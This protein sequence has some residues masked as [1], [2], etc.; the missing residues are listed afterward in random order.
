MTSHRGA[1]TDATTPPPPRH[2]GDV[3]APHS[4]QEPTTSA[5][6]TTARSGQPPQAG[7]VE[8][9]RA[10][11]ATEDRPAMTAEPCAASSMASGPVLAQEPRL[12]GKRQQM[13]CLL[14]WAALYRGY[15]APAP[16]LGT[17]SDGFDHH[18]G[19]GDLT[20]EHDL[21]AALG[22]L[23]ARRHET[24]AQQAIEGVLERYRREHGLVIDLDAR[25]IT[26]DSAFDAA[27]EEGWRRHAL[28]WRRERAAL[29]AARH[30]LS[31]ARPPDTAST[32][33]LDTLVI[34][35]SR[36][37]H[38][39]LRTRLR[40][41]GVD[42]YDCTRALFVL[43]YLCWQA[44]DLEM[45]TDAPV[46]VD[47]GADQRGVLR[48][49]LEIALDPTRWELFYSRD[50]VLTGPVFQE[51]V[52]VLAP[53]DQQLATARRD[54][55]LTG[56]VDCPPLWPG[57]VSRPALDSA[58]TGYAAAVRELQKCAEHLA[59]DPTMSGSAPA[60][61]RDHVDQLVGQL[62]A[63]RATILHQLHHS[64]GLL[65]ME[66]LHVRH[67][68]E[69]IDSGETDLPRVRF[70]NEAHLRAHDTLRDF[71]AGMTISEGVAAL[72]I[73][74]LES[75]GIPVYAFV[76]DEHGPPH[77]A[78]SINLRAIDTY[79]RDLATDEPNAESDTFEY[80][81]ALDF[82]DS[83]LAQAGTDASVR[84]DL[85]SMLDGYVT[86]ARFHRTHS[87]QHR[88]QWNR[89]IE[90]TVQARTATDGRSRI[91]TP[92]STSPTSPRSPAHPARP[93]ATDIP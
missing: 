8:Q 88:T 11:A 26:V 13:A 21:A 50:W 22:E 41:A 44:D 92:V 70:V 1:D 87:Q 10:G 7:T 24:A 28:R 89:R 30:I 68:V 46:L 48:D 85:R 81:H 17:E 82:L 76:N 31:V 91:R 80:E 45:L 47:P 36:P 72:L 56:A 39:Q 16:H 15:E 84:T 18:L 73:G 54:A 52:A 4:P 35:R 19:I 34:P 6:A 71:H 93:S 51:A 53:A 20:G 74:V 2:T 43:D 90:Q 14:A 69:T 64:D 23:V 65:W 62:C 57:T 29:A 58:L 77:D 83:T 33:L 37:E 12:F 79:V 59:E 49:E 32:G 9:Y 40:A 61:F 25:V 55:I 3:R 5:A 78:D 42:D 60:G 63:R 67:M 66:R 86:S 27:A 75:A 38:D